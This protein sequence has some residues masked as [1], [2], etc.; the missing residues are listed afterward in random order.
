VSLHTIEFE[1]P[2]AV[3]LKLLEVNRLR[4]LSWLGAVVAISRS[5]LS[6]Y[7]DRSLLGVY[8]PIYERVCSAPFSAALVATAAVH[9]HFNRAARC[10]IVLYFEQSSHPFV[11]HVKNTENYNIIGA[12]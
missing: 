8:L 9:Y 2:P 11:S 3:C 10:S 7:A 1:K 5:A 12:L 6:K 4:L